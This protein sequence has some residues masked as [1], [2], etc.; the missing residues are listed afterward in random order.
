MKVLTI[1]SATIDTI[2]IIASD[3]IERMTMLNAD[4]SFLLLKDG[5]KTEATDIS[6][7]CGGGAVNVAVALARLG[8]DA[9]ALVKLGKDARADVILT[10]LTEEGVSTR[11]AIRD[12]RAPTGASVLVSS[13]DRNA[14]VFTFRGAN[15]LLEP[16]DLVDDAFAVDLVYV[17]SLSDRS[18]DSFA[19]IIS[20]ARAAKARI[21]VNPGPR[22]LAA[23]GRVFEA[24]LANVDILSLNRAE[25][26]VLVPRLIARCGEGGPALDGLDL[27]RLAAR[28]LSGGGFHMSLRAFAAAILRLGVGKLLITDGAAGAYLAVGEELLHCPTL[29]VPIA[30]TAGAGDAF[31]ATFA[32][33]VALGKPLADCLRLASVNAA[34]VV[35]RV[36][37][38]SGLL[39]LEQLEGKLAEGDALA[40]RRWRL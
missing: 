8:F 36:D 29:D 6:T 9:G 26:E 33:F 19:P 24:Q 3:R 1:G 38:Q 30:G 25:A 7:H 17:T 37:T 40:I 5:S 12:G 15:T 23:R 32:G 22:Q 10:R 2:A 18:A 13:H 28:G 27:P 31:S 35:G 16:G 39:G 11:W 4:E 20:K 34:S 21:A 14:A